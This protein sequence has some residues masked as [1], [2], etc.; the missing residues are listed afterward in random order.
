MKK[1]A[2]GRKGAYGITVTFE[3]EDGASE[4][5]RRL[6]S[7]NAR[8][9]V[10]LE[11]GCLRFDV[12]QPTATQAGEIFLYEIYVDRAAFDVH[13]TSEHFKSFDEQSQRLVRRK[14]VKA[15]TVEQNAK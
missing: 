1:G 12:L 9:S 15:F 8:Q 14:T 13:L 5:F 10:A 3:L 4:A 2:S 11:P 7:E 6:V